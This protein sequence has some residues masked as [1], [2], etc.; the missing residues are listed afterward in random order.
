M[1]RCAD[2]VDLVAELSEEAGVEAALVMGIIRVESNF[3]PNALSRSGA[4]GLMQLMP[5]TAASLNVTDA[6]DPRQKRIPKFKDLQRK[7][8]G[9]E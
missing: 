3:N 7:E 1:E 5:R 8:A 2:T 9:A 6:F 4:M